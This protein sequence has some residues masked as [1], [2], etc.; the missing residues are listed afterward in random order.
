[1]WVT[2]TINL[3]QQVIKNGIPPTN[4]ESDTIIL[5]SEHMLLDFDFDILP[6]F[7]NYIM[8]NPKWSLQATPHML[9][10]VM[11]LIMIIIVIDD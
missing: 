4:E 10:V 5:K 1:M 11:I 7:V 3:C 8:I 9:N 6:T 2:S